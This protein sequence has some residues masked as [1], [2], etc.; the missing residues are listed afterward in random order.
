MIRKFT[1][2]AIAA[3]LFASAVPA[4]AH[5]TFEQREAAVGSTYRAVLRVPH[6][7]AG[8]ATHTVHVRIPEG[9]FNVKPMP[10]VG[11][12]LETLT[13]PYK[14]A[15]DS[16]GKQ[17]TEGVRE[18]VWSGG[19]LPDEWYDEFIF[20]G[21]FAGDLPV[22]KALHFPVVQECAGGEEAW[23]DTTGGEEADF[24]A[25]GVTLRAKKPAH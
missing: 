1:G 15:Y 25:P 13:G 2:A 9:F 20:R 22:D 21:T 4:A 14:N 12:K 18:I 3:A 24:P 17:V 6:G 7:C 8:K 23:I 11:W 16:H 5:V 19:N 10:K